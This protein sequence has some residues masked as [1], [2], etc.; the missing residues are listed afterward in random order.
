MPGIFL[1]EAGILNLEIPLAGVVMKVCPSEGDVVQ[2]GQALALICS[3]VKVRQGEVTAIN[4]ISISQR[5]A[6]LEMEKDL[7]PYQ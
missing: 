3:E 6:N 7:V 1:L 2:H 4:I 5:S